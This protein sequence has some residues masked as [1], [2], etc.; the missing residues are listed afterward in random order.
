MHIANI[1]K[2]VFKIQIT[3]NSINKN[4]DTIDFLFK[5]EQLHVNTFSKY[6][7]FIK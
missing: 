3:M 7:E 2:K 4:I 1:I 5:I 6:N